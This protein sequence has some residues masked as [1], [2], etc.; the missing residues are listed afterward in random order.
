[1]TAG[2]SYPV[3]KRTV[4]AEQEIKRSR[5][6]SAVGRAEDRRA[7]KSFIDEVRKAYP[8]ANHHCWAY[9][10]GNP[11]GSVDMGAG[12]DGEPAGTAGKPI[13]NVLRHKNIGEIVAVVTRY[14]G[15]VKLGTGGLVRA[16]ASSVQAAIEKLPLEKFVSLETARI[17]IPYP[18]E[19]AVRHSLSSQQASIIDVEYR[20]CVIITVTF[21]ADAR[22]SFNRRLSDQ[23][24]GQAHLEAVEDSF[25]GD[26]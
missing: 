6:I 8:D 3:P 26:L 14:F 5:F 18:Y 15:G 21:P 22:E 19:N 10:A 7:A 2:T 23:T 1:M 13:L 16:Y 20:E 12:D 4:W 11:A 9:I 17:S 24:H 25:E